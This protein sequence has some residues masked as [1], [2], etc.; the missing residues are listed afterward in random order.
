MI[1]NKNSGFTLI[2]IVLV[3]FIIGMVSGIIGVNFFK[4]MEYVNFKT[5]SK[6]LANT[7]RYYRNC[8]VTEKKIFAFSLS[9]KGYKISTVSVDPD[10]SDSNKKDIVVFE[11]VF[12]DFLESRCNKCEQD[13]I[14]FFPMGNSSGGEIIVESIDGTRMQININKLTGKVRIEAYKNS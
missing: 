5:F 12:A 11:K 7:L 6:E 10:S 8:A 4:S 13:A 2:E 14:Y 9:N 1:L 3:L